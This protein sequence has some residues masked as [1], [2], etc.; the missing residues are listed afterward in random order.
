[1][2]RLFLP[3]L[4]CFL[5]FWSTASAQEVVSAHAGVVHFFEGAVSIDNQPLAHKAAT[6]PAINPN[7]SLRTERGRAEVLLTP[8]VFLRLDENSA[9]RMTANALTATEVEFLQGSAIIDS[10]EA[11]GTPPIV[12]TYMH[13]RIRFPKPGIYRIDSDT[14]VL[15]AYTGQLEVAGASG[16]PVA[17]DPTKL[18]FFELEALTNK[19]GEPNEDEFYDWARGRAD[20]ISAENQVAAQSMADPAD[21]DPG[22]SIFSGGSLPSFGTLAPYPAID[23]S[24][25]LGTMFDPFFGF[26]GG[27][28]APYNVFPIFLVVRP[29]KW[30]SRWPHRNPTPVSG[31]VGRRPIGPAPIR[32]PIF[33]PRPAPAASGGIRTYRPAPVAP[34]RPVAPARIRIA[35]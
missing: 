21:S 15:Q 16:K 18:Y 2:P 17:V 12:L 5:L 7:S 23:N 34:P 26:G 22:S 31:S 9:M 20:A 1:M 8:G 13:C 35:H 30:T 19:F 29:S 3:C 25:G 33:T 14:G 32:P 6:F 24:Y 27:G 10:M 11:L 28:F 4:A